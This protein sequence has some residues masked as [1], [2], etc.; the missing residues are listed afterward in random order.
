MAH[1]VLHVVPGIRN[2]HDV[3][4]EFRIWHDDD[5]WYDLSRFLAAVGEE[6]PLERLQQMPVAQAR[7]LRWAFGR[8]WTGVERFGA[9]VLLNITMMII[10]QDHHHHHQWSSMIIIINDHHII[11]ISRGSLT[12]DMCEL[13]KPIC[14][15]T[16][17]PLG[18]PPRVVQP[19]TYECRWRWDEYATIIFIYIN[20]II[21]DCF[22]R[23]MQPH[24][25][26]YILIGA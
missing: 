25:M 8:C 7:N 1:N 18:P 19:K 22:K 26:C 4:L 11:T 17:H 13:C 10:I 15:V 21:F 12:T 6:I 2:F 5:M 3:F 14:S 24:T 9:M 20:H 23:L 16:G